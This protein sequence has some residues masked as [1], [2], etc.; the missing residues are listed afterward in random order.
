MRLIFVF[1]LFIT[2]VAVQ[3]Q[4]YYQQ[5]IHAVYVP[6]SA[7]QAWE[8]WT[9]AEGITSFFAPVA[10]I[11][12]NM[13]EPYEVLID[14]SAA[15]GQQ[16]NEGCIIT[17]Y[18]PTEKLGF[19]WI[20]P[21][22]FSAEREVKTEV[23]LLFETEYPYQTKVT[24]AQV[25]WQEGGEWAAVYDYF[26]KAW[27]WVLGEFE[28]Y[29]YAQAL[30]PFSFLEG[31]WQSGSTGGY[32]TWKINDKSLTSFMHTQVADTNNFSDEHQLYLQPTALFYAPMHNA[33]AAAPFTVSEVGDNKMVLDRTGDLFPNKLSYQREGNTLILTKEGKLDGKSHTEQVTFTAIN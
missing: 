32:M 8:S 2:S 17:Q 15:K 33:E 10:N 29:A 28:A 20:A 12:A 11:G 27:E 4:Q 26:D 25:G 1:L 24:L 22:K 21:P 31:T 30:A 19:Q 5:L 3:A 9:T 14:T 6:I 13:G 7:E 23:F 16:G 18:K